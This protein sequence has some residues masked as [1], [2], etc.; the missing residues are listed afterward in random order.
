MALWENLS[1]R[2][3]SPLEKARVLTSLKN[4]CGVQHDQLVEIYL[5]VLDLAPHKNTLRAY[6][7]L[8][9]LDP[10]LREML[11]DGRITLASAERLSRAPLSFQS[12][13]ERGAGASTVER[14]PAA[15]DTGPPRGA[16]SHRRSDPGEILR[17]RGI[18]NRA[19]YESFAISKKGS[20]F[21]DSFIG[22][23]IRDSRG[24]RNNSGRA[25]RNCVC[26]RISG[27]RRRRFL[28]RAELRV[29]FSVRSPRDFRDTAQALERAAQAPAL[30]ALFSISD[31]G[32]QI[33]DCN[34]S[35]E[36]DGKRIKS[37]L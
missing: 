15:G 9:D 34:R 14:Q 13:N 29:E 27:C 3:L 18:R 19:R 35:G 21:T 36:E 8:H 26:R 17:E 6:L 4:H 7:A 12:Q 31:C 10:Q 23:E 28:S 30:E 32:L 24:Q 22:S 2:E 25:N 1:H 11:N 33:A 20:G 5:P 37:K 16:C